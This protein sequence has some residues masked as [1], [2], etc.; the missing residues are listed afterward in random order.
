MSSSLVRT[1]GAAGAASSRAALA[2]GRSAIAAL[3]FDLS[4]FFDTLPPS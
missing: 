2:A 4:F 3:R 1:R